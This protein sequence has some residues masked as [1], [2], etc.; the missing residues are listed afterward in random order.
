V[1]RGDGSHE[2]EPAWRSA[3]EGLTHEP[4][5][6]PDGGAIPSGPILVG[7]EHQLVVTSEPRRLASVGQQDEG[8]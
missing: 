4:K 2:G 6:L 3:A 5:T 1:D 7:Q 8:Q